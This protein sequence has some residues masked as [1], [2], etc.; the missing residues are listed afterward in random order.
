M[1]SLSLRG[2]RIGVISTFGN[3]GWGNKMQRNIF[4]FEDDKNRIKQ[5]RQYLSYDYL[6]ITDKIDEAKRILKEKTFDVILLDHDMDHQTMV[7]STEPNTG[8][9]VAQFICTEKISARQVI[10]HSHNPVGA[11]NMMMILNKYAM[12]VKSVNRVPFADLI[13]ILKLASS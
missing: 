2:P 3:K 8:F 12:N 5:F 4:I 11:E 6:T 9:Q 10:V 7:E 13:S 1:G